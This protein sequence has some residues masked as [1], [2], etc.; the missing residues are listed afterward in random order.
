MSDIKRHGRCELC[1]QMRPNLVNG[2]AESFY[3]IQPFWLCE[4]CL[5]GLGERQEERKAA[6]GYDHCRESLIRARRLK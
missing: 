3:P 5:E 2:F 6:G 4:A 1:E